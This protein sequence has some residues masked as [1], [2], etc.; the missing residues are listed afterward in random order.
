[1]I[2]LGN[3]GGLVLSNSVWPIETSLLD[4]LGTTCRR[5]VWKRSLVSCSFVLLRRMQGSG[6]VD[7][8]L[9]WRGGRTNERTVGLRSVGLAGGTFDSR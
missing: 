5:I 4:C 9:F 8:A 7:V 3:S 1:M 2:G 6:L